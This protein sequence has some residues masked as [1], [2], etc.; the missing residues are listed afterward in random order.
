MRVLRI[1]VREAPGLP[2][3]VRAGGLGPHLT[4]IVGPNASGKTTLARTLRGA[5][6]P[7]TAPPGVAGEVEVEAGTTTAVATLRWGE[8]TW[9]PAAPP[10]PGPEAAAL[11]RLDLP[12][13]L[14]AG[15]AERELARRIAVELA[16]GYDL[17][18][19]L[20]A[21]HVPDPRR[22]QAH[23]RLDGAR[24]RVR[25][26]E[27][28][29]EALAGEEAELPGLEAE[30][31]RA[32]QAQEL[33]PLAEA[34][35]ELA[36]IREEIATLEA[37]I[38]T[39]PG[40]L[41]RLSGDEAERIG[42][43]RARLG[44]TRAEIEELERGRREAE[45]EIVRLRLRGEPPTAG[46]LAA[47]EERARRLEEAA[48]ELA[49]VEEE[50]ASAR[51]EAEEASPAPGA[52]PAG[53]LD[54]ERV[55]GL[56]RAL[57]RVG[58]LE[59]ELA[60][61]GARLRFWRSLGR[62]ELADEL[63]RL[64]RADGT[65]R[66]WLAAARGALPAP[67]GWAALAL[68]GAWAAAALALG[69]PPWPAAILAGAG[70]A[71]LAAARLAR[72]APRPDPA[73][74][75]GDLAP[76]A[77]TE[78]EVRRALDRVAARLARARQ[79]EEA[80]RR[81][82]EAEAARGEVERRL[83]AARREAAAVAEALGLDPRLPELSL[84]DRARRLERWHAARARAAGL[85]GRR[86][87][88]AG[89]VE[90]ELGA[91]GE[92]L[93]GL[94]LEPPAV[95][96]GCLAA[97]VEL[98]RRLERLEAAHRHLAELEARLRGARRR[99]AETEAEL[100]RL[101]ERIGLDPG[102]DAALA[103]RLEALPRWR[104]LHRELGELAARARGLEARLEGAWE[105][106]GLDPG[107]LNRAAAARR[108]ALAA[109]AARVE[110]LAARIAALRER[111]AAAAAGDRLETAR[112][113]VA[114]AAAE[115]AARRDEAM[116]A[117]L[118]RL[119]LERAR[120]A[121]ARRHAPAVLE[122][123]RGL[124]ARF[125]R[126]A[127]RLEVDPS[128]DLYAVDAALG[129]RR[130]LDQLSDGTRIHLLLAARLAA[131]EAA[132]GTAGPLPLCL[133]EALSTTHPGRF[134]AIARALAGVAGEG[135]QILYLAADPT[136]AGHWREA[137]AEA[138]LPAPAVVEL[139]P[140]G[141]AGGWRPPGP[142]PAPPPPEPGE[143]AAAYAAR[144]GLP[145]PDPFA[146]VDAWPV[147]WLLPDRLAAVHRLLAAGVSRL[148]AWRELAREGAGLL[149][150]PDAGLLAARAALAGAALA[151]WRVGRGRPVTWA[152][153]A[154][155]GAVSDRFEPAVR[156]LL[157]R[158]GRDPR[159]FVEAVRALRGFRRSKA[160]RLEEHLEARGVLD[161]REPLSA[162]VIAA[163]AVAAARPALERT[164][165]GEAEAIRW[166]LG[167]LASLG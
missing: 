55:A 86:R 120:D 78:A 37:E 77:W 119:V 1:V 121:V 81:A 83:E 3:G 46:A 29:H 164:G 4:V 132:E 12:A 23:A 107:A 156:E 80:A 152:D 154:D 69:W 28:E 148:G 162:R 11:A 64:E 39:L 67:P 127:F 126:G 63:P 138:G 32:R 142:A 30:L 38:A 66:R 68:A 14:A 60:A 129:Q 88:L 159:A 59:A 92:L 93:A 57:A 31:A 13:L 103:R 87:E 76:A 44:E 112:A 56:E 139:A 79:A 65:L 52:G 43:I 133:D 70:A 109:E 163:R 125:T 75:P 115:V 47:W 97:M 40:G 106:L 161:R 33:L 147:V 131:L 116:I 122:R 167:L 5:L 134:R 26:L 35:V 101:W 58:E 124:F 158:H 19:A 8:V 102:E 84:L 49:G 145:L 130:E 18:A 153:V 136:E 22:G 113:A 151:A 74:L 6:W 91:L 111:L 146:G 157:E 160:D 34:A 82:E 45:A 24:Q 114:E 141:D 118:T 73:D 71:W 123:A 149:E 62:R 61:A 96:E 85:E 89:R 25:E 21:V 128:G 143:D 155:S 105:R 135:R 48:R 7:R 41:E 27:R 104:K 90:R 10:L 2:G 54:P 36:G 16:G 98:R 117:A 108:E 94:G 165:I 9:A 72:R 99:A 50:L 17:E 95:P 42:E 15:E 166:V 144:L 20:A 140:A 150:P 53:A 137:F 100:G 51:A 110:E